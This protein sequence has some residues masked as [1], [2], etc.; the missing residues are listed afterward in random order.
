MSEILIQPMLARDLRR[1]SEITELNG[2]YYWTTKEIREARREGYGMVAHSRSIA[3]AFVIYRKPGELIE[4]DTLQVH[5]TYQ[6]FG[7]GSRLLD[8]LTSKVEGSGR[9]QILT[10][11]ADERSL[12]THLFLS[13]NGFVA[14]EIISEG[15]DENV[16]SYVFDY[17]RDSSQEALKKRAERMRLAARNGS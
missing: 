7:I 9:T 2:E 12:A 1:C 10:M 8:R 4:I 11:Q 15:W 17:D 3:V 16:D 14:T 5:P 13:A 6:R